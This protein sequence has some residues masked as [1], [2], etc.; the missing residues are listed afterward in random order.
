MKTHSI[1]VTSVRLSIFL[2]LAIFQGLPAIRAQARL[3]VG[4]PDQPPAEGG[5]YLP[6][7]LNSGTPPTGGSDEGKIWLPYELPDQN[8]L[9][10]YGASIAVDPNG[11]NHAAYAIYTG[12]DELGLQPATYAYCASQCQ[13][14][15]R[16]TFIHLGEHVQDV[17]LALDP[18]GRP[19]LML[20]GPVSD[21]TWPRVRYQYAA[22]NNGCTNAANWTI[23]TIATPIEPVALR[24]YN[25]NRYFAIDPQGRPAFLYTDTLQNNHPGTFYL[26]CQS[27]CTKIQQWTETLLSEYLIDKPSLA[28]SANGQPRLAFG[29]TDENQ[30]LYLAYAECNADCTDRYQWY[31]LLLNP[32]HGSARFNLQVD[33]AG[34]PRLGFYSGSYAYGAFQAGSLYYLWCDQG[35]GSDAGNWFLFD[36]GAPSGSGD[37]V[38]LAL[39]KQDRPRMSF[40]I[41][42]EGLGYAWCDSNCETASAIWQIRE[43][44]SQAE[45][46][47]NY[48]VLPTRRCTVSTWF[49]GERTSLALDPAGNPRFGYDA[50]H[51]WFGTEMVNGV[52]RSC[53]YKD[54]NVTRFAWIEQP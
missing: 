9:P 34:K 7:I 29:F 6:V 50:Q 20:F 46:A 17:R 1:P 35:C 21:P 8:V 31:S 14:K 23:T 28:F 5:N 43:V 40:Q 42:G 15:A 52:P 30:D 48:E 45:L 51:W 10:T 19:R 24:E 41:G 18:A 33:S 22:C 12:T 38:D 32:I 13:D 44:E 11:G 37:G 47:D 16:W 39:D 49:N 36:S 4:D 2:I 25:N 53:S 26:S 54:I 3:Q 27:D